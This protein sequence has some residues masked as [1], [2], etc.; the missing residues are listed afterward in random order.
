MTAAIAQAQQ[1]NEE[2]TI[3]V[4]P[5]TQY[6]TEGKI[7]NNSLF[8]K[9]TQWIVDNYKKE[10][11]VYVVHEGDIVNQGDNQPE[12]WDRAA[13]AMY[14]LEKP[15]PGLPHGIPYGMAVGNHDQTPSQFA[16]TGGTI[17][18][19]KYFGVDHFKGRKYYGGHFSNNNDSHYDLFSAGG[20]DFMVI[21]LEYDAM[22]EAIDAM[23]D[24][25]AE[26]CH[27]YPN[28]KVIIVSHG[29]IVNNEVQ[30]INANA[31]WI[32]QGQRIYDRLKTCPN[33]FMMLCGHIGDN[34]EGY[35]IDGYAG[36]TIKTF[37]ADYQSRPMAGGGLMRLMTFDSK[38]DLIKVRTLSPYY[39]SEETDSDSRFVKPWMTKTTA[40]RQYDYNNDSRSEFA[41]C[42]KGLWVIEG[43]K[44]TVVFGQTKF[45]PVPADYQADGSAVIASYNPYNAT[46]YIQGQGAVQ[47]G[48]PKEY[49]VPGDYDGDGLVEMATW[50][51]TTLMWNIQGQEPIKHGFKGCVVV[52]ADYDGDGK[53]EPAAY[54]LENHIFY[55]AGVANVPLGIDGDI[56]VPADYNGDGRAEMAVYRPSTGEWIVYGQKPVVLG[57]DKD[58]IP[59][60]ADYEGKKKVQFAVFNLS[61]G[62]LKIQGGKNR[63]FQ[64]ATLDEVANLPHPIRQYIKQLRKQK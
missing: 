34:G 61:T 17:G 1:K 29:I 54:R 3:A 27:K 14:T 9:Q 5:D 51:P 22:D 47:W 40:T 45:I 58:D 53:I 23:N 63:Q 7:S 33:V 52:P 10:N 4:L 24:W 42:R 37:L 50:N 16:V 43:R 19:N 31:R 11:I 15:Q 55:I 32:K 21:Y 64:K 57:G 30:G 36:H 8:E 48:N 38:N 2:F 6:Y 25:A 20:H 18:Y 26:L 59:V 41:L 39:G 13:K 44:D 28:R 60:P 12:A 46:F 35:R 56:P 62:V 49:P